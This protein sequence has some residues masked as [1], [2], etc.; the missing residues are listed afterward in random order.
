M[1]DSD[2]TTTKVVLS[3]LLSANRSAT[4]PVWLLSNSI[5][6]VDSYCFGGFSGL[7]TFY[8]IDGRCNKL[9][10]TERPTGATVSSVSTVSVPTGNYTITSGVA[11]LG[12]ALSSQANT[13]TVSNNTTS[14]RITISAGTTGSFALLSGLSDCYYELGITPTQL[15]ATTASL[16]GNQ[17]F[18]FSGIKEL[19]ICSNAFGV[20]C[21]SL[22]GSNLSV[23]AS[24]PVSEAFNSVITAPSDQVFVSS[25]AT[26]VQA[27]SCSLVDERNRTVADNVRDWSCSLYIRNV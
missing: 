24:V 19:R 18:D 4:A 5:E 22:I 17:S 23:L 25:D 8:N 20:N 21:N 1:T 16:T 27:I 6:Q 2:T 10:L 14:N 12:V 26:N 7:N 13:Y 15:T 3:T 9:Y 11:A